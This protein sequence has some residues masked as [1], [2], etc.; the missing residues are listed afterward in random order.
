MAPISAPTSACPS[1]PPPAGDGKV[2]VAFVGAGAI[3]FGSPTVVWN[4]SARIE[5]ILGSRLEV[6]FIVD[7]NRARFDQIMEEKAQGPCP[8]AYKNTQFFR[9]P[10]EAAEALGSQTKI[11]LFLLASPPHFRGTTLEGRDL[12]LEMIKLFGNVPTFFVEKPIATTRPEEPVQV[13]K[14]LREADSAVGIGYMM[15]YL[16]VVQKVMSIIRE[17]NL[18]VMMVTGRYAM[19]YNLLD[20]HPWWMKSQQGGPIIEQATHFCDLMRYLGG[21]EVDLD[22]VQATTLEHNEPAGELDLT[23]IDEAKIEPEDRV[24][25]ATSAFW[26]YSTGAIG[27]LTHIVALHGVG[28]SNEISVYA[29]GYQFRLYDLYTNP[30]LYVRTPQSEKEQ[31][32][33]YDDDDM[34]YNEFYAF[35]SAAIARANKAPLPVQDLLRTEFLTS[36]EDACK[37]FELTWKIRDLSDEVGDKSREKMTAEEKIAVAKATAKRSLRVQG[38]SPVLDVPAPAN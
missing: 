3:T 34:F 8:D 16:K 27:S 2:T 20:K 31:V 37:T 36:Y 29:D 30:R 21:G 23:I 18:R 32:Y 13:A 22:S 10:Q 9:T 7:P 17:N 24:P 33:S 19:A 15:R 12:E 26:K 11:D 14:I 25:R 6:P 5:S 28:Y 35:V 1:P 38:G 4:H